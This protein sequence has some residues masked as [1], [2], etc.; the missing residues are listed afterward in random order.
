MADVHEI[1]DIRHSLGGLGMRCKEPL[2]S[3]GAAVAKRAELFK[4][5]NHAA[6]VVTGINDVLDAQPI[7]LAFGI[8]AELHERPG[9]DHLCR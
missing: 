4:E 8:A 2:D 5:R 3:I 9:G 1:L 6:R 7:R